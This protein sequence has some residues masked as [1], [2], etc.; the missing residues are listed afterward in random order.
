M[1][2]DQTSIRLSR[3]AFTPLRDVACLACERVHRSRDAASLC[4]TCRGKWERF[5]LVGKDWRRLKDAAEQF[6]ATSVAP[7][8]D[9]C[10]T[11]VDSSRSSD[12]WPHGPLCAS[13]S[14]SSD[15][16]DTEHP[17]EYADDGTAR[18]R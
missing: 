4:S 3:L 14:K 18:R 9:W 5:E 6:D 1:S 12:R 2:R 8:C 11:P 13:C 16:P 7:V 17:R 10:A 15:E